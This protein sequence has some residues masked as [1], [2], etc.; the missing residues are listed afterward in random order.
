M[1]IAVKSDKNNTNRNA[2][3][4]RVDVLEFDDTILYDVWTN[5]YS[6]EKR[7]LI[8]SII[9]YT[10]IF[11]SCLN[12]LIIY[13][14][15]WL[16]FDPIY[17]I[18]MEQILIHIMTAY[19]F[20]TYQYDNNNYSFYHSGKLITLFGLLS[21]V[22]FAIVKKTN[23]IIA[24][25]RNIN[26]D[27]PIFKPIDPCFYQRIWFG[28]PPD[29]ISLKSNKV[30]FRNCAY[31][32]VSSL[33][34]FYIDR[35]RLIWLVADNVLSIFISTNDE[36]KIDPMVACVYFIYFFLI[37]IFFEYFNH[38]HI[39]HATYENYAYINRSFAIVASFLPH[40]IVLFYM[41]NLFLHA[42]DS[43]TARDLDNDNHNNSN[44]DNNQSKYYALLLVF[45]ACLYLLPFISIV[46]IR[47][48]T[49]MPMFSITALCNYNFWSLF[50]LSF[51]LYSNIGIDYIV[52]AMHSLELCYCHLQDNDKKAIDAITSFMTQLG[53]YIDY[54]SRDNNTNNNDNTLSQL[55]GCIRYQILIFEQKMF[56]K[57]KQ[58][59]IKNIWVNG[60]K[61]YFFAQMRLR[62]D[63]H[64][65]V[66]RHFE[67]CSSTSVSPSSMYDKELRI[68]SYQLEKYKDIEFKNLLTNIY[69]DGL[70][71]LNIKH[72]VTNVLKS[73]CNCQRYLLNQFILFEPHTIVNRK[74]KSNCIHNAFKISTPKL[75][76]IAFAADLIAC[77]YMIIVPYIITYLAYRLDSRVTALVLQIIGISVCDKNDAAVDI[78]CFSNVSIYSAIVV[79]IVLIVCY[80]SMGFITWK[81]L[82]PIYSKLILIFSHRDMVESNYHL[83]LAFECAIS[84]KEYQHV[85][86]EYFGRQIIHAIEAHLCDLK[87]RKDVERVIKEIFGNHVASIVLI[88]DPIHRDDNF[89]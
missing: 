25:R 43:D 39:I 88:Y 4:T 61:A 6:L 24:E 74:Q 52:N 7:A 35:Y 3:S 64:P 79:I 27:Q 38:C 46:L 73:F 18:T 55:I 28:L 77:V 45:F 71:G 57:A 36:G 41:L 13:A 56:D 23:N 66:L 29:S 59:Q 1:E 86:S 72:G 65:L 53:Y 78:D 33:D 60:T 32:V 8:T 50:N 2:C 10:F 58:Q 17:E 89:F 82:H 12:L 83:T 80:I 20:F 63:Q 42:C 21:F 67:L 87:R 22:R 11:V 14:F 47:Q 44:N 49:L 31:N 15:I 51:A 16:R 62:L 48:L 37:K 76:L 84:V 34:M 68:V 70:I 9:E 85:S 26:D 5:K 40:Y 30:N 19:H 69:E 75:A 54:K 81:Y